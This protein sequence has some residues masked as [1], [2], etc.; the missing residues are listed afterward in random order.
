MPEVHESIGSTNAEALTRPDPGR[1]I[2]AGHQSSG[3]GRLA[4]TWSAPAGAS[5]AVTAVL[6]L[7]DNQQ[8]WGWVPLLVGVAVREALAP[9]AAHLGL[10]WPN[11]VL[12]RAD[13]EPWRKLVGILCQSTVGPQGPVVVVGVGIN[14]DLTRDEL[15]VETATS[16]R[17]LGSPVT[18]PEDLIADV[19][20][21]V[22]DTERHLHGAGAGLE[23]ARSTYRRGCVT[24]GQE[25]RVELPDRTMHGLAHAVDDEGRIVLRHDQGETALAVG[26]VVHVRAGVA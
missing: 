23:Q 8:T 25:V 12:A 5:V 13:D 6:P 22:A 18:D 15:P 26:D 21:R 2:V 20:D 24:L 3:R 4:R 10:K 7:P 16:L 1:V 19:L 14:T 9:R 11:D 17:L